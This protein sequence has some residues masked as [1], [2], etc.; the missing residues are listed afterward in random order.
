LKAIIDSNK[1]SLDANADGTINPNDYTYLFAPSTKNCKESI[2]ECQFL[3]GVNN[4]NSAHQHAYSPFLWSF[5]LPGSTSTYRGLGMN[6]PTQDLYDEFEDTDTVRRNLSVQLG[7]IDQDNGRWE[8]YPYTIKFAD[9]VNWQYSGSNFKALRYADILLLYAEVLGAAEGA[10]YLNQVRLRA[11][12]P[13]WGEQGYPSD[14]YP[15][16]D[17]ALEHERRVEL[18]MEYH[19][20]FDLVRTGRAIAVINSKGFALTQEKL[21]FPIPVEAIDVNPGL[22]QNPG[23]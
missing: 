14:K 4:P 8:D 11:G 13:G 20:F 18:A 5:H 2:L 21:L 9:P 12:L 19:R 22:T 17:L 23:Y 6:T 16:F 10:A 3:A 7:F 15:T 1:Y